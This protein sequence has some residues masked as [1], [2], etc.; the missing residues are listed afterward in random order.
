MQSPEKDN[1]FVILC[2]TYTVYQIVGIQKQQPVNLVYIMWANK[3]LA[4]NKNHPDLAKR[5]LP[6]VST[7]SICPKI[8]DYSASDCSS[9]QKGVIWL[10]KGKK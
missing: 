5:E 9:A 4:A 3:N 8:Q 2:F 7:C 1:I 10:G 6:L